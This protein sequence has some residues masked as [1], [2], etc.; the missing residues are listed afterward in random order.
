MRFLKEF[1]FA[2]VI[3]LLALTLMAASCQEPEAT[4]ATPSETVGPLGDVEFQ[5]GVVQRQVRV[6]IPAGVLGEATG[7][8]ARLSASSGT[9]S[10]TSA[11]E[12]Q[13]GDD[14]N[15]SG[16]VDAPG[17]RDFDFDWDPPAD[18][19]DG[20]NI[21]FPVTIQHVSEGDPPRVLWS[22]AV[23]VEYRSVSL[24]PPQTQDMTAVIEAVGGDGS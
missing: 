22:L 11:V 2:A 3:C 21:M 13:V 12:F 16:L 24:V 17:R 6:F 10:A 14:I 4:V 7:G 20:C 19:E 9:A 18:C 5:D 23:S 8:S 1:R 15:D